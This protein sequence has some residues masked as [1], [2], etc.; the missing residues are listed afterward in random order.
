MLTGGT[1]KKARPTGQK[2]TTN[3][4]ATRIGAANSSQI[5]RSQG[6][7]QTASSA[8]TKRREA[9][10]HHA[11]ICYSGTTSNGC[12]LDF[13]CSRPQNAIPFQL[14]DCHH[15]LSAVTSMK[16]VGRRTSPKRQPTFASLWSVHFFFCWA[17]RADVFIMIRNSFRV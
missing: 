15:R 8:K 7:C 2:S 13:G 16:S 12:R 9:H 11:A 14:T 6:H 1:R 17:G 4:Q 5:D 3:Q 10:H